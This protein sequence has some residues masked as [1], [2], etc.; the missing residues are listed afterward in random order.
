L[1][2]FQIDPQDRARVIPGAAYGVRPVNTNGIYTWK[3][4]D[5]VV[6]H[7]RVIRPANQPPSPLFFLSG[8]GMMLVGVVPVVWYCRGR[9]ALRF[10]IWA[11]A[12]AWAV[13][14]ALKFACAIPLND[15]IRQ[16]LDAILPQA[17]AHPL[18]Y[19]YIGLLTG[20]FEC[21]VPLFLVVRTRLKT[22]GWNQAVAFGIG[23]G[24]I[25]AFLLGLGT[26]LP[27]LAVL[28]IGDQLP[29]DTMEKISGLYGP[30]LAGIPLPVIERITALVAHV[31][32]IVLIV[33]GVRARQIR[34][35]WMSFAYK[36]AIDAFAAWGVLSFG[37]KDSIAKLAL[38]EAWVA[39]FALIGLA[40]L[41]GLKP[42]FAKA[43][44]L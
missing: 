27:L 35:F 16:K 21:V 6:L 11:G 39:V 42:R 31:F 14:V 18:F 3:I 22:A 13:A 29:G 24:A 1:F 9:P 36:T 25:E 12:A 33:H 43:A 8:L 19:V 41:R 40:G 32:A 30:G 5:G 15:P 28:V 2:G 17:L 34:W 26:C 37:A 10:A 7:G 44:G 4:K 20:I 23:F 38:F